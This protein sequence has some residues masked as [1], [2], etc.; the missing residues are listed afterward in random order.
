MWYYWAFYIWRLD[1][2]AAQ[3]EYFIQPIDSKESRA[4]ITEAD[5]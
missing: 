3:S 4:R 1:Q 5:T 2:Q